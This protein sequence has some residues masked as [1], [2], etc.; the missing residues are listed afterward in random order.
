MG[1]QAV[2]AVQELRNNKDFERLLEGLGVLSQ[3]RLLDAA[4]TVPDMRI[5][6]TAYAR[7]MYD[8]WEAMQS[9]YTGIPISQ[10]KPPSPNRNSKAAAYA[11]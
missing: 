9:A 3:K 10:V 6:A 7:G 5:D 8:L 11:E 4:A 1:T 2:T